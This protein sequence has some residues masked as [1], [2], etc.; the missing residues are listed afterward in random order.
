V[1]L[2]N[3]AWR[4]L[5]DKA[6]SFNSD[7]HDGQHSV[8]HNEELM[9]HNLVDVDLQPEQLKPYSLVGG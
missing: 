7:Y 2:L 5:T 1:K 6:A 3:F 9:P 4:G 8:L